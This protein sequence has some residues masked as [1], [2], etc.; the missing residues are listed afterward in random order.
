MANCNVKIE[1]C[2]PK[3]IASE[4]R[5]AA[6]GFDPWGAVRSAA[7]WFALGCVT[8]AAMDYGDVW[9]CVGQCNAAANRIQ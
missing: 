3:V 8:I 5:K 1:N 4:L 2:E 7:F 6:D 9:F